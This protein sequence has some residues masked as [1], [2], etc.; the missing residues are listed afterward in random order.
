MTIN[1][2]FETLDFLSYDKIIV[3]WPMMSD[4]PDND[5]HAISFDY[6][7][8]LQELFGD[9]HIMTMK[10]TEEADGGDASLFINVENGNIVIHIYLTRKDIIK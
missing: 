2:L 6:A 1:D 5:F 8:P 9:T 3:H 4:V 7:K 10:E